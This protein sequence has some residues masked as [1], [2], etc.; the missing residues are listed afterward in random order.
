[1]AV[2]RVQ[3]F[4]AVI[5]YIPNILREEFI[6]V[7]VMLV[8]PSVEF[9]AVKSLPN[10][11]RSKGKLST[12]D[13]ADGLFVKHAITKLQNAASDRQFHEYVSDAPNGLL[14]RNGFFELFRS[15]H[16]NVR[17][18]EPKPVLTENPAVTLEELY[19]AFIGVEEQVLTNARVT[20]SAMRAEVVKAFNQFR[21]FS[22]YPNNVKT[23][24]PLVDWASPVDIAYMNG[25]SHFYQLVPFNGSGDAKKEV[26]SYL[27]VARDIRANRDQF[28]VNG[29]EPE[30][31]IFAYQP[32]NEVADEETQTIKE[33]LR[34]E[35][36]EILDY[37]E[38]AP[39][40]ASN[41]RN[42]LDAQGGAVHATTSI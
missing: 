10:F 27:T 16:N 1:M 14:T 29:K 6:N 11:N 7:A 41:I 31:S 26:G 15:Y 23:E 20:R 3:A 38:D 21:L 28:F 35:E 34:K 5:R 9:Q 13:D 39:I 40:V 36:I 33:R 8:C 22:A 42:A 24:V 2:T 12:F 4:Y 32:F 17:M 25:S 18:T 30:F 19:G 37:L